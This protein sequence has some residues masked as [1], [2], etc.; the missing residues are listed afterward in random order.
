[1][2]SIEP[3]AGRCVSIKGN[4]VVAREPLQSRMGREIGLTKTRSPGKTQGMQDGTE[5][6]ILSTRTEYRHQMNQ[7]RRVAVVGYF[8][9][10]QIAVRALVVARL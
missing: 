5:V 2:E 7:N 8:V 1:M 9:A 10:A 6:E 3:K 4:A